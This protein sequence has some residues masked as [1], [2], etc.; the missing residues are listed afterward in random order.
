[1]AINQVALLT[2]KNKKLWVANKRV[3]KKRQKRKS[4]LCN[5]DVLSVAEAQEAQGGSGNRVKEETIVIESS[6]PI[7]S[8]HAPRMCSVYR[9][10]ERNARMCPERQQTN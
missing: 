9:S 5:R 10:L 7:R 8:I 1:L 4:Y 2:D 3:V 6:N